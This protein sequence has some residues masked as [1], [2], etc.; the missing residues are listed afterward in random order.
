MSRSI[1]LEKT[2]PHPPAK[3]WK[4]VTSSAAL[5]EWLME[6]DFRPEV[7][8]EFQFRTE[9]APGFDGIVNC[10][11]LAIEEERRLSFTWVGG[12]VDTVV[13]WTLEPVA[14]GT[15]FVFEQTGFEGFHAGFVSFILESG[16]RKIYNKMLPDLLA[17][18]GPDGSIAGEPMDPDCEGG[19][20]WR[21]LARI[22]G[23]IFRH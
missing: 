6:N 8:H 9:P 2:Y 11:V 13:T 3:V 5:A 22:G 20:L 1:R 12:P 17:R 19:G 21:V 10:R 4:A 7:G 14:A 23:L 18:M 15:R 16:S